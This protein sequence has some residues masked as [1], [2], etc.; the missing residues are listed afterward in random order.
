MKSKGTYSVRLASV[1]TIFAA[2]RADKPE[3]LCEKVTA[4]N[5]YL[6]RT[7]YRERE[8]VTERNNKLF[9][10]A[11]T[12]E[13][14]SESNDGVGQFC[15]VVVGK[16]MTPMKQIYLCI[17][18]IE[19]VVADRNPIA[20]FHSNTQTHKPIHCL[21]PNKPVLWL[22]W[23]CRVYKNNDQWIQPKPITT[24]PL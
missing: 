21:Q 17:P 16:A 22:R 14:E 11:Q 13:W 5:N 10:D 3:S 7:Q 4:T 24:T 8:R 2:M 23:D 20:Q 9:Y 12:N 6:R 18:V 19:M 15:F 1:I